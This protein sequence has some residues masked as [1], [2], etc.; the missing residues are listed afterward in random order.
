MSRHNN[1]ARMR[2]RRV[3]VWV[4]LDSLGHVGGATRCSS[5]IADTDHSLAAFNESGCPRNRT[6]LG[7]L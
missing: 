3:R 7:G 6:C 4:D 1:Y 2:E 5:L